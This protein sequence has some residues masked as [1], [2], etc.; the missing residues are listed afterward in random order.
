M[1]ISQKSGISIAVF[2]CIFI[3]VFNSLI[4]LFPQQD[5]KKCSHNEYTIRQTSIKIAAIYTNW[6]AL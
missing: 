2:I 1:E 5:Y 3:S 6:I 4:K